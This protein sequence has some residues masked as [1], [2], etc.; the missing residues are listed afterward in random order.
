MLEEINGRLYHKNTTNL[1]ASVVNWVAGK[2]VLVEK[3]PYNPVEDQ[4]ME[5][6]V[7]IDSGMV[8]GSTAGKVAGKIIGSFAKSSGKGFSSFGAFKKAY[9]PAGEGQAWHHIVEQNPGNLAK[10]GAERIHNTNNL[11]KLLMGKGVFMQRF[12]V[13]TRQNKNLLMG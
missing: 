4:A 13:I 9:G 1:F 12:R 7:G 8:A 5:Q 2:Q 10:F 11:I 6:V 3:K